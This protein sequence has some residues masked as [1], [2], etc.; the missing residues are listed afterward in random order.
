MK[1]VIYRIRNISNGHYYIG[2]T[3]DSRK[4]FWEHRK[5]LRLG[6]HVCVYLQRAWNKYGEDFF[7][8]EIVEQL[9]SRDELFPAE[10][11]LLDEHFGKDY[12][13]NVAAYADAPMRD[14]SPEL[15]QRLAEKTRA[16]H[17]VNQHPRLGIKLTQEERQ[18]ISVSRVGKTSGSG[19]YRYGGTVS[20]EVREKIG[21]AQRGKPKGPGRRVSPEG[22]AK[23]RAAAAAG[24][25]SHWK[26]RTHKPE[27]IEKM[28]RAIVAVTPEGQEKLYKS[29]TEFRVEYSVTPPTIDRALKSGQ[30]L[31]RGKLK[32]WSFRYF[33]LK[34]EALDTPQ[35]QA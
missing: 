14:A 3:V 31:K 25:Y 6:T 7:K 5:Q 30:A 11:R 10:Q 27:S 24:S 15:R 4:R 8:F 17:Q 13:Y 28:S 1:N 20:P 35:I 29:I 2:S 33:D 34:K 16:W 19:H 18:R 32:G 21:A 22:M 9:A 23:I 12:C 26:G